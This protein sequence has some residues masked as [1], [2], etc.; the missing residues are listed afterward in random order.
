MSPNLKKDQVQKLV[1]KIQYR[2]KGPADKPKVPLKQKE[3][4]GNLQKLGAT[5]SSNFPSFKS[6]GG[7][8][9]VTDTG[10]ENKSKPVVKFQDDLDE[11]DDEEDGSDFD[12]N[13]LMDMSDYKNKR[14]IPSPAD[15]A[16]IQPNFANAKKDPLPPMTNNNKFPPPSSSQ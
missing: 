16:N 14:G 10:K 3:D 1:E 7:L 2:M 13:E 11:Y 5:P 15:I 9:S 6:G 4:L 8:P 12:A